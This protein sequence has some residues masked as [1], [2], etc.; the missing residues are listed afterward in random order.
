[1]IR[2]VHLLMVEDPGNCAHSPKCG[3]DRRFADFAYLIIPQ[4]SFPGLFYNAHKNI[5]Q[6]LSIPALPQMATYRTC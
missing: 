2:L 1:M 4:D 5:H 3:Q 6:L